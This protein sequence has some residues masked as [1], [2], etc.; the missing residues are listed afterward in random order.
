MS[1]RKPP[2][3]TPARLAANRRNAQRSTGPRTAR[4]KARSR[5]NGLR[6]GGRSQSYDELWRVIL[7][8]P[9]GEMEKAG[10]AYL[11]PLEASHPVFDSVLSLFRE[12]ARVS[13]LD[14]PSP[15]ENENDERSQ[16]VLQNQRGLAGSHDLDD[17]EGLNFRIPRSH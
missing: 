12:P 17:F 10:S 9:P 2:S 16:N 3:L 13:P 8:A 5:W 11:S 15:E 14:A 6:H 1:L 7:E 4:G